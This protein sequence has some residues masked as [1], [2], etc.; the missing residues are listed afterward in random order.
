M[1]VSW[2]RSLRKSGPEESRAR[3]QPVT[4]FQ[5]Q[6]R[7]SSLSSQRHPDK[8]SSSMQRESTH[9]L[10][11]REEAWQSKVWGEQR[12]ARCTNSQCACACGICACDLAHMLPRAAAP[13][14]PCA[15]L[16]APS[17]RPR[18]VMAH[19]ALQLEKAPLNLSH[20]RGC[21]AQTTGR[22]QG[23]M[24]VVRRQGGRVRQMPGSPASC[25]GLYY[26]WSSGDE[27]EEEGLIGRERSRPACSG[28]GSCEVG[29]SCL[30]CCLALP[31]SQ[32]YAR[33]HA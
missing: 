11:A 29:V 24:G 9:V 1:L 25:R 4:P 26:R 20:A 2:K 7:F 16:L 31:F 12:H 28:R 14:Q 5:T 18:A 30:S 8:R 23:D 21:A 19:G 22:R 27:E 15:G 32:P 17:K 33:M 10:A 3:E 13:P 6:S